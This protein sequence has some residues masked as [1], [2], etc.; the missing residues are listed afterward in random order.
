MEDITKNNNFYFDKVIMTSGCSYTLP[1]DFLQKKLDYI[2]SH[3]HAKFK[4]TFQHIGLPSASIKHLKKSVITFVD[5]FLQ[6]GIKTDNMYLVG[7]LTQF[8][9][10]NYKFNSLEKENVINLLDTIDDYCP[11]FSIEDLRFKKYPYG[12]VELGD[13]V[14]TSLVADSEFY[15]PLYSDIK[16]RLNTYI[17]YHN[18]LT[19]EEMV[20]DYFND[21]IIL[22]TYL[23]TNNIEYTLFFMNNIIEGWDDEYIQ[24]KY[25][26]NT[27][28]FSV[29]DLRNTN[30]I[31]DI[32]NTV[33]SLFNLIDFDNIVTYSTD[34]YFYGGIDEYAIENYTPNHLASYGSIK[35]QDYYG[36]YTPFFGQHPLDTVQMDFEKTFIYPRMKNFINKHYDNQEK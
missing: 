31:K 3:S 9:R 18:G 10:K 27:G 1:L 32:N 22:Q 19:F 33:K 15:S 6:N 34:K 12:F 17:D 35:L 24:H 7:N 14:Y 26:S 2:D 5:Y 4:T 29:P 28:Y 25:N 8:G 21:L 11:D 36:P 23:K 20:E 30:N 13:D 16:K